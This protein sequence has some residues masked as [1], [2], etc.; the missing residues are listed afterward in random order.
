MRNVFSLIFVALVA[1]P[2]G[3]A[4]AQQATGITLP[5][6]GRMGLWDM[7]SDPP[8]ELVGNLPDTVVAGACYDYAG[9]KLTGQKPATDCLDYYSFTEPLDGLA[10]FSATGEMAFNDVAPDYAF[11]GLELRGV[12]GIS[13]CG[14]RDDCA[15]VYLAGF[16][17]PAVTAQAIAAARAGQRVTL[18]GRQFWNA[19]SID[20]IVETVTPAR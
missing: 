13:D 19:E 14:E 16:T 1:L 3:A 15:T 7:R 8:A 9:N 10:A 2:G 20:M 17:D 11:R 6:E 4:M 18:T 5:V 12:Q